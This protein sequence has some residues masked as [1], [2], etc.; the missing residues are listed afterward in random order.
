VTAKLQAN[1]KGLRALYKGTGAQYITVAEVSDL[2]RSL[3][4]AQAPHASG[5]QLTNAIGR[6]VPE[7]ERQLVAEWRLA[8][9][10]DRLQPQE[11]WEGRDNPQIYATA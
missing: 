8:L 10:P 6:K 2:L 9:K 1:W 11:F 5:W 3:G 4:C 7:L